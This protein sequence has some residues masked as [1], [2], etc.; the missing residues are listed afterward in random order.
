MEAGTI[1]GKPSTERPIKSGPRVRSIQEERPAQG[2]LR[3]TDRR[4]YLHCLAL[5]VVILATLLAA[6]PGSRDVL[7]AD[8]AGAPAGPSPQQSV[9]QFSHDGYLSPVPLATPEAAIRPMEAVAASLAPEEPTVAPEASSPAPIVAVVPQTNDGISSQLPPE[10]QPAPEPIVAAAVQTG[11]TPAQEAAG[12]EPPL[13]P[14]P[15]PLESQP[16]PAAAAAPTAAPAVRVTAIGDSVMLAA[17][18]DLAAAVLDIEVD[19]K[20]GRVVSTAIDIL[21]ARRNA[22]ELG[23]VVVVHIGNNSPF[24]ASEFEEMMGLLTGVTRAVFVNLKVPREWEGPNNAVLAAGVTRYPNAVLVDWYTASID[25]PQFLQD[26]VHLRP[27]GALAY[28][29]LIAAAV[30][31]P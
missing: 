6:W 24:T 16:E 23:D 31:S 15:A 28:A 27:E 3:S 5:G 22:D 26:G 25:R 11:E 8:L 13:A 7:P 18:S 19:A 2:P 4:H 29:Q 9:S 21:R 20:V 12:Q 17:A 30:G 10:P 1:R 14:G